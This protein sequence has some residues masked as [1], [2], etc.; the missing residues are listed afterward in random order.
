MWN[1]VHTNELYHHGIKGM[2]WGV[3]R[4]QNK[5]GSLTAA[6]MKRISKQYKQNA[7]VVSKRL[8]KGYQDMYIN[9]Y[10]KSADYMNSGV[11]EKFNES[12]RKKYGENYMDRDG[13]VSDYEKL[14]D[15][16]FTENLNK[17]LHDFYS[18]DEYYKK[19]KELV[20]KYHMTSWDKLAHD[21]E[22]AIE[23][24]R[25]TVKKYS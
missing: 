20:D 23:E 7:Q 21:N 18:N 19:S 25:R 24:L 2:K 15:K 22:S 8:A 1:Y 16:V 13:Y 12:Q 10:N 9:A 11:T 4:Y 14:F 6:G 17:S 3:R 5:D